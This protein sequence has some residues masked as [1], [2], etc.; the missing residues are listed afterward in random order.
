MAAARFQSCEA[1]LGQVNIFHVFEVLQDSFAG[2]VRFG[3]AGA[4]G[5]A[6]ETFFDFLG[7]AD[8]KHD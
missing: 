7:K 5:E 4:L 2:V 3:A 8:G 1:F 6:G